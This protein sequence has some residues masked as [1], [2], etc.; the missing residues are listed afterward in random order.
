MLRS[1]V[2]SW[3]VAEGA[4]CEA[5]TFELFPTAAP[6]LEELLVEEGVLEEGEVEEQTVGCWRS[7]FTLHLSLV[8][9]RG[10]GL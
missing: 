5:D 7:C 9:V 8:E 4:V 1:L 6:R 10:L 2:E 3:C